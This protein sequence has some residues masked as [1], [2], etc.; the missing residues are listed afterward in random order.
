MAKIDF[1]KLAK[2]AARIA[3]EKKA[4][5]TVILDVKNLTEIA[6]YFVITTAESTPQINA[7]CGEVEK[8]FKGE[9]VA[10][11][12]REGRGSP[13]WSVLDY[14][15]LVIHVMSSGTRDLYNL[16]KLWN[17]AK[18]VK[19]KA[20][21]IKIKKSEIVEKIEKKFSESA[22][23]GGKTAKKAAAVVKKKIL[24]EKKNIC[25]RYGKKLIGAKKAAERK[26]ENGLKTAESK[27]KTVKRTLKAFGKGIEAFGKTLVKKSPS[28][29][30][31]TK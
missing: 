25:K 8:A 3:D 30:K 20:P 11:V 10:V 1:L 21:V 9:G 26:V 29:K 12:R 31:K 27:V 18:I 6:D 5:N 19:E 17:G 28:K 2:E 13:A 14:G 23:K 16:E 4:V 24:Q 22:V 15:G 7:V